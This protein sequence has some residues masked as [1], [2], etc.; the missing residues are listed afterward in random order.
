MEE[1]VPS[2][3]D[4]IVA[5]FSSYEEFLDSHMKPID[6]FYLEVEL[7]YDVTYC[8]PRTWEISQFELSLIFLFLTPTPYSQLKYI[9]TV[10]VESSQHGF[11]E[12]A[13]FTAVS[14]EINSQ[15]KIEQSALH[16]VYPAAHKLLRCYMVKGAQLEYTD[17]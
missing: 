17:I 9:E 6:L 2:G 3:S 8:I 7:C 11:W 4:N 10:K 15:L 12:L 16:L 13:T 14:I 5:E 1:E